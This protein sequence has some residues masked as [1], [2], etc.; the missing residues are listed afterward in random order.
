MSLPAWHE[1][2]ISKEHDRGGFDCGDPDMNVFLARYV[3]QSHEQNATKTYCAIETARPGHV[4][5]FYSIAPRL[6]PTLPCRRGYRRGSR[7]TRSQVFC[8]RGL[9]PINRLRGRGLVDSCW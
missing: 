8:W 7:V 4:L 2:P 6:S 5:G 9:P 1:E 3:R